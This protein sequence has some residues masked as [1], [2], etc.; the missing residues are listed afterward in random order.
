[1][2]GIIDRVYIRNE[3]VEKQKPIHPR[4]VCFVKTF[5]ETLEVKGPLGRRS[6]QLQVKINNKVCEIIAGSPT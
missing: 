1:M 3:A 4:C 5:T 6:C 2:E